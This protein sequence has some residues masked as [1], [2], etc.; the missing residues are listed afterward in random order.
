MD[1][2]LVGSCVKVDPSSAPVL[3]FQN[4]ALKPKLTCTHN[5]LA[6]F[7]DSNALAGF[8][9]LEILE[10]FNPIRILRVIFQTALAASCKPL[11]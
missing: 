8:L 4:T 7:T 9:K 5:P 2:G 11:R 10:Q 1:L 6:I 3:E